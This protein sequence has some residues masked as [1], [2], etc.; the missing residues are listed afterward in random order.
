VTHEIRSMFY[1]A[2]MS[3][4]VCISYSSDSDVDISPELP[5]WVKARHGRSSHRAPVPTR[6]EGGGTKIAT[7]E[8]ESGRHTPSDI[9]TKTP[10]WSSPYQPQH[11]R[12]LNMGAL[13]SL[14]LLAIPSVGTVSHVFLFYLFLFPY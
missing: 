11:R 7:R 4:H 3:V 12:I 8:R 5:L 13:L 1:V 6:Q 10:P 2:C 9:S 14:P